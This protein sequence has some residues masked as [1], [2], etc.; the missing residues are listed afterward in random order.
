MVY[1]EIIAVHSQIHT[2]DINTLCGQNVGFRMCAVYGLSIITVMRKPRG[3]TR[4]SVC[5]DTDEAT[6]ASILF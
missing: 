4:W 1:S 2:K 6:T 3:D 5:Q